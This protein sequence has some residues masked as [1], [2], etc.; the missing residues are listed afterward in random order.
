MS[1]IIEHQTEV[2]CRCTFLLFNVMVARVLQTAAAAHLS[3]ERWLRWSS[4]LSA[5]LDE[6]AVRPVRISKVSFPHKTKKKKESLPGRLHHTQ[7]I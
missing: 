7:N 2:R 1:L 6:G 3:F 4:Q 5:V